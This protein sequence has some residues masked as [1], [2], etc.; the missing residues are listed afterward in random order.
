M[1]FT[2]NEGSFISLATGADLTANYR[3]GQLDPVLGQFLGAN[4]LQTLLGQTG[5]VGL[6]IYYGMDGETGAP[7]IVVVGVNSSQNDILGT[8]PLILDTAL[9][10]PSYCGSSNDLNS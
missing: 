7:T 10:C 1:S 4:K 9:P 5:C 3:S 2:G 8:E 6:R